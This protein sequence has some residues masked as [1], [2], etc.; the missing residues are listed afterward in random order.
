VTAGGMFIVTH[1][2]TVITSSS[3]TGATYAPSNPPPV[4]ISRVSKPLLQPVS[5][6][7]TTPAQRP[8]HP[9]SI[10]A[11]K[12]TIVDIVYSDGAC[13]ANG[14]DHAVGGVGVWWGPADPRNLSERCPGLQ[15]NN[16]AELIA[17]AR[18]LETVP[19]SSNTLI[20]RTDSQ[21]S[22]KALTEWCFKW[23]KNG[24]RNAG[25]KP[26]LNDK[27]ID[28]ILTLLETRQ[29]S[30]QP[31]SLEYV[32]GHSGNV[33]NDGADALAVAG[34]GF[35]VEPERDWKRLKETYNSEQVLVDFMADI[36]VDF[37]LSDEDLMRELEEDD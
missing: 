27:L 9:L 7:V 1:A 6:V 15:T 28:Y 33:G 19:Q 29:R 16:R 3:S 11:P 24:W 17:I 18:V 13:K 26:V 32:K 12:N 34:C 22:I 5:R 25:G 21:Y 8:V 10:A 36:D 2:R 30:G 31:V 20:I 4:S 23:R 14:T 35:P 37:L